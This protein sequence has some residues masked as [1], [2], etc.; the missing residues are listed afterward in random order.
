MAKKKTA[1]K[2]PV[3][4]IRIAKN[5]NDSTVTAY[6]FQDKNAIFKHDITNDFLSTVINM[7][8]GKV[9]TIDSS[10]GKSYTIS[11]QELPSKTKK[12]NKIIH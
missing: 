1:D 6:V 10:K 4:E 5:I 2:A 8:A 3:F 9:Q 12:T 7:W 11:V